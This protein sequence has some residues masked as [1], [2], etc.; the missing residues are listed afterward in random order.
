MWLCS[1]LYY[2]VA[3]LLL[4]W[5]CSLQ[6]HDIV[7]L[8]LLLLCSWP[9]HVVLVATMLLSILIHLCVIILA[10]CCKQFFLRKVPVMFVEL[11]LF[12]IVLSLSCSM[13]WCINSIWCASGYNYKRLYICCFIYCSYLQLLLL[14]F[15]ALD[16]PVIIICLLNCYI[17]VYMMLLLVYEASHQVLVVAVACKS[18]TVG[19]WSVWYI[20]IIC[21]VLLLML[22]LVSEGLLPKFWHKE[23]TADV[24]MISYF[25]YTSLD[26]NQP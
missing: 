13:Q 4:I 7:V 12:I 5:L 17:L 18:M 15:V 1:Y 6:C 16:D 8:L 26:G 24:V 10:N 19:W 2:V 3:K 25:I 23:W 9:C 22:L 21:V 11:L 20:C 14:L